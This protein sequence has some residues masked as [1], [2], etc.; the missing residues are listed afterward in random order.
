MGSATQ[1]H[2]GLHLLVEQKLQQAAE[3]HC[4]Q[5]VLNHTAE[6][7]ILSC[8]NSDLKTLIDPR[9]APTNR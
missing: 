3:Q 9:L 1:Q 8:K 2:V 7:L 5:G 4:G 6:L